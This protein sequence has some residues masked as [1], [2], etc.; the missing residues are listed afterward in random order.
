MELHGDRRADFQAGRVASPSASRQNATSSHGPARSSLVSVRKAL[1]KH[2]SAL[3][4]KLRT[5]AGYAKYTATEP[6]SSA[7]TS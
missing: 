3:A 1:A 2:L 4:G 5:L 7:C 6:R